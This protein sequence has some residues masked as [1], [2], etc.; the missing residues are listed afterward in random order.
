M[1]S[2]KLTKKWI[3][4]LSV[5]SGIWTVILFLSILGLNG[6]KTANYN[7]YYIICA[8]V[9][10]FAVGYLLTYKSKVFFSF[11]KKR[12]FT[13]GK[14]VL[15]YQIIYI[16]GIICIVYFAIK[17]LS[18]VSLYLSGNG[19]AAIR[20]LAQSEGAATTSGGK[21]IN[22]V[23]VLIIMPYA[24]AIIP[25]TAMEIWFGKKNKKILFICFAI[26][27]L[28]VL[29]EGGRI[30]IIYFALHLL[31]GFSFLESYGKA[32]QDIA[33]KI[34]RNRKKLKIGVFLLVI[35]LIIASLS[36][37]VSSL[38]TVTYYYFSMQP[39]MQEVWSQIVDDAHLIGYGVGSFNGF[40]F[41][42]LYLFKN[43]L[44]I[45]FPTHFNQIYNM[46]LATDSQWQIIS[47][48]HTRA[49]AYVGTFWYFYL[50]GRV[51]GVIL[52]SFLYGVMGGRLYSKAKRHTNVRS[53]CVYSFYLQSII[54]S[55]SG[56]AFSSMFYGIAFLFIIFVAYKKEGK[57]R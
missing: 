7:T 43:I 31:I 36:R 11:N 27:A 18:V 25:I 22:A 32:M 34:R 55:F 45:P 8:G 30:S 39:Y 33:K 41:P 24:Y 49:N 16:L 19:L 15:Q 29:S 57:Y 47:S 37:S 20:V 13:D 9:I 35:I 2:K 40:I 44:G 3:N 12:T 17:L 4:P 46:I 53:V 21:L 54:L 56:F 50:D 5:F 52:L 51:I 1:F 28:R 6:L 26:I 48:Y 38:T 23:R 10:S 14:Y 42:F